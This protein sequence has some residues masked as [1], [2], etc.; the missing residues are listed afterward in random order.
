MPEPPPR[1]HFMVM[2]SLTKLCN[3]SRTD[4]FAKLC[5]LIEYSDALKSLGIKIKPIIE[6][7]NTLESRKKYQNTL[8]AVAFTDNVSCPNAGP[9]FITA[10]NT[11]T[12]IM[13]VKSNVLPCDFLLCEINESGEPVGYKYSCVQKQ[14]KKEDRDAECKHPDNPQKLYCDDSHV[15]S[16]V[17]YI[18]SL[19][20]DNYKKIK[21]S[22]KDNELLVQLFPIDSFIDFII[23]D[24][25]VGS[26]TFKNRVSNMEINDLKEM[27]SRKKA[28]FES[29]KSL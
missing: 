2:E 1:T 15:I 7:H 12:P 3:I 27:L 11:G 14:H 17:L 21:D 16:N 18:I 9:H 20:I 6:K 4:K 22:I 23:W 13:L 8:M 10:K 28:D 25:Y 29:I 24:Y 26:E 19:F 5:E